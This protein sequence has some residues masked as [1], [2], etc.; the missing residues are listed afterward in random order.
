MERKETLKRTERL[1]MRK[2]QE[3]KTYSTPAAPEYPTYVE[4]VL[5]KEIFA[6]GFVFFPSPFHDVCQS[7]EAETL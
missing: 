4:S 1:G 5:K 2:K 3:G 7:G 6:C